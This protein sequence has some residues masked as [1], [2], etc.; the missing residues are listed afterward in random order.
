M[1]MHARSLVLSILI[2]AAP[3]ACGAHHEP[4]GHGGAGRAGFHV[5]PRPIEPRAI[6][7]DAPPL[8]ARLASSDARDTYALSGKAGERL[9]IAAAA[10]RLAPG[11]DGYDPAVLDPVVVLRDGEQRLVAENDDAWPAA[12]RDAQL[13]VTLPADGTYTVTVEGCD[14]YAVD[15]P[16]I[17][18]APASGVTALDYELLVAHTGALESPETWAGDAQDGSLA[19]AV[20]I[21][22]A[23]PFEAPPDAPVL[24]AGRFRAAGEVHVFSFTPPLD[25]PVVPGQRPRADF[26][27]QPIGAVELRVT[28]ATGVEVLARADQRDGPLHLSVP[29]TLGATYTLFVASTAETSRP[30]TD[31]YFLEHAAGTFYWGSPEHEGAEE[32][33]E[34]DTLA[35][36]EPLAPV[37]IGERVFALDGDLPLA[38]P[39]GDVDTWAI[40]VPAGATRA[41]LSCEAAR[42]GSGLVG[43]SAAILDPDGAVLAS[44]TESPTAELVLADVALGQAATVFVSVRAAARDPGI[45]GASYRCFLA[46]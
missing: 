17:T 46:L 5:D 9:L 29:V 26:W 40:A 2:G 19:G 43:F 4:G 14:A 45:A 20:P 25:A 3:A 11:S 32:Q 18:C 36:A 41:S 22:Y 7:A 28:D 30:A 42:A 27:A 23:R 34:N 31:F 12:G 21:A 6:T 24:V 37:G 33:G 10:Q 44:G 16:G 8:R 39:G 38:G 35:A 1:F 13:F 15:R